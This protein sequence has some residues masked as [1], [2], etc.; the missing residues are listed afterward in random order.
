MCELKSRK[1]FQGF[2]IVDVCYQPGETYGKHIDR[3]SRI[4]VILRGEVQEI[5]TGKEVFAKPG[6]LVFKPGDLMHQNSF[7][8]KGG[9]ILSVIFEDASTE[10]GDSKWVDDWRWH[11]EIDSTKRAF[12]F[13]KCLQELEEI[14]DIVEELTDLKASLIRSESICKKEIPTWLQIV[15]ENIMDD[16]SVTL[17]TKDLAEN[18]GV[19][20]VYLARAFRKYYGCSIKQ[21]IQQRRI[22]FVINALSKQETNISE[23]AM[24]A[25]FSDQSHLTRSF[26]DLLDMSP[27]KFRK[28]VA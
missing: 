21:R 22:D 12:Q 25:G 4:S 13:A 24:N 3:K 15:H 8:K 19:H 26:K 11:Q 27:G 14:D 20:P 18:M 23:I 9:R 10:M 17:R 7:G 5:A 16:F 28:W 1:Q 2:S 6:N